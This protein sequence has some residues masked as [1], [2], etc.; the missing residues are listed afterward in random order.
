MRQRPSSSAADT[1]YFEEADVPAT[2]SVSITVD[3]AIEQKEY[4]DDTAIVVS[5][6]DTQ[7]HI[8]VLDYVAE[9]L[10]P[11]QAVE[12]VYRLHERWSATW[13]F[14]ESNNY[15]KAFKYILHEAGRQRSQ[16]LPVRPVRSKGTKFA[17]ILQ[18]QP[19]H[20][21]GR[22]HIRRSQSKLEDQLHRYPKTRHDD[23][24]DA[25]AMRV[26]RMVWAESAGGA[27]T[28]GSEWS[29]ANAERGLDERVGR[30]PGAPLIN[31][32]SSYKTVWP[33]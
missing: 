26:Q 2:L 16:F 13:V 6:V 30:G 23:V 1:L 15:Q 20:E 24:L 27:T 33:E 29:F 9:K 3:L 11:D 22:L 7:G 19:F 4:S 5:G 10:L 31:P 17:R 14:F 8:W 28:I 21:S 18:L 25:L 12:H 32:S